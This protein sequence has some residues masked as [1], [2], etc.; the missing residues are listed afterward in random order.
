MLKNLAMYFAILISYGFSYFMLFLM[1]RKIYLKCKNAAGI[2]N[3]I[4]LYSIAIYLYTGIPILIWIIG[5]FE[6]SEKS[7]RLF[8][9]QPTLLEHLYISINLIILTFALYI[10]NNIFNNIKNFIYFEK[11]GNINNKILYIAIILLLIKL[12]INLINNLGGYASNAEIYLNKYYLIQGYSLGIRQLLKLIYSLGKF[13]ELIIVIYFVQRYYKS[14]FKLSLIVFIIILYSYNGAGS[15]GEMI[16][17]LL[18]VLITLIYLRRL[19]LLSISI[20]SIALAMI[21]ALLS[22]LRGGFIFIL[23]PLREFE[24]VWENGIF[25][26][27]NIGYKP[28]LD[29]SLIYSE[30]YSLIPSNFLWFE[31]QNFANWLVQTYYPDYAASGGGLMFGIVAHLVTL[32]SVPAIFMLG[33][34]SML[35]LVILVRFFNSVHSKWWAFPA[36][37]FL[38]IFIYNSARN[39]TLSYIEDLYFGVLPAVVIINILMFIINLINK[40]KAKIS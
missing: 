13:S 24:L 32:G 15:R 17:L 39:T 29:N 36:Y 19:N 33:T 23:S 30:F 16:G 6:Y 18:A 2:F 14:L 38:T 40:S 7:H 21:F 9:L 8:Y 12:I 37:L 4:V 22:Y 27:R 20:F 35:L 34:I 10:S 5:G 11:I 1:C 31:K 3:P 26:V 28:E 25:L